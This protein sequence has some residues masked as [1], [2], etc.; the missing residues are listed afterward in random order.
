M[1]VAEICV[2]HK[3]FVLFRVNSES[4]RD[5]LSKAAAAVHDKYFVKVRKQNL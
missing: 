3:A 2:F 4:N 1:V 5:K